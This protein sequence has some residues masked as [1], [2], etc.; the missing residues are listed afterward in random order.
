MYPVC[1]DDSPARFLPQALPKIVQRLSQRRARPKRE[2]QPL[3]RLVQLWIA[4][5]TLA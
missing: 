1:G 2:K 5:V 4:G 3:C